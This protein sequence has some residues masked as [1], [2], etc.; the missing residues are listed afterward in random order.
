MTRYVTHY[1]ALL[2]G[3]RVQMSLLNLAKREGLPELLQDLSDAIRTEVSPGNQ[4]SSDRLDHVRDASSPPQPSVKCVR[5]SIFS[6]F[7]RGLVGQHG[8]PLRSASQAM[9]SQVRQLFVHRRAHSD[10]ADLKGIGIFVPFVTDDQD[11]KRL[12]SRMPTPK[13]ALAKRRP[14]PVRTR[15]PA[16]T[17]MGICPIF[18]VSVPKARPSSSAARDGRS[19]STMNCSVRSLAS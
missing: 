8:K 14:R 6:G 9:V 17:N 5:S 18:D 16:G 4:F 10:L 13:K 1:N 3:E 11:L 15:D 12:A 2:S 19:L 7:V